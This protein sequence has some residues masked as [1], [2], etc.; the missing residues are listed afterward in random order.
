VSHEVAV[1]NKE[2]VE[3]SMAVKLEAYIPSLSGGFP[4]RGPKNTVA[5]SSDVN[6]RLYARVSDTDI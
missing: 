2:Y 6:S 4:C 3:I 5:L 1:A